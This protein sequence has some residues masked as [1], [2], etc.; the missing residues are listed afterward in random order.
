M[1]TG[2]AQL[3]E[4]RIYR[5]STRI[6]TL[7]RPDLAVTFDG[8]DMW[9]ESAPARYLGDGKRHVG[10]VA[11]MLERARRSGAVMKELAEI[12]LSEV[13][14]WSFISGQLDGV[15]AFTVPHESRI[16]EV[17]DGHRS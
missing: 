5:L 13:M 4:G 7:S 1:I 14:V 15:V 2:P 8:L 12:D 10:L 17:G 6:K 3:V 11:N 16:E 9:T